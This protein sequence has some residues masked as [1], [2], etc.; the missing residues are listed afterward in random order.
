MSR[1]ALLVSGLMLAL[2]T[3]FGAGRTSTW[4]QASTPAAS[5]SSCATTT[6]EEN[7]ELVRRYVDEVYNAH[8]PAAADALLAEDFN[9]NNPA[10][11]HQNEPGNA[12]DVARVQRS[13]DEFPDLSGSIDDIIASGDQVAALVTM[14]G[15]HQGDFADLGVAATG[16][17][18]EW[19][20]AYFW[21]IECGLL[22]E[23][24]VVTDRLSE[25][26]QLG[27]VSDDELADAE[28]MTGATP[29]P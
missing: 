13:L 6:P 27:I 1:S 3:F 19:Q 28:S 29:V 21:R 11:S 14:R 24:W 12:D 25:Y 9:R 10:R 7:I 16:Q 5:P 22:A 17:P 8:D 18:A 15:T 20:A 26:R 23:N 2:A 4:A